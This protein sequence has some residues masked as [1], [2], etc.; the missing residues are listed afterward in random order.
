MQ[1]TFN[2]IIFLP[3]QGGNFVEALLMIDQDVYPK[4]KYNQSVEHIQDRYTQYTFCNLDQKYGSWKN[5]HRSY[6]EFDITF[7]EFLKQDQYQVGVIAC[8]AKNWY[9]RTSLL[10]AIAI[11][12]GVKVN[13]FHMTM[14]D[15]N[16]YT[17]E[18]LIA[19]NNGFPEIT[20]VTKMY[21]KKWLDETTSIPINFDNF[22]QGESTFIPEYLRL[23]NLTSVTPN[24]DLALLLYQEWRHER[25]II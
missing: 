5:F 14:S 1:K 12:M 24:I 3:G 21:H 9:M 15:N 7:K 2:S 10:Y 4:L 22:I 11:K 20:D 6:I 18:K 23:C 25:Q 17:V 19:R 13:L 16:Q 8:H